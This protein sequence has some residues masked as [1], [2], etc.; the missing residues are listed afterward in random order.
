[1]NTGVGDAVGLG[2]ALGAILNGWGTPQLLN[3]YE[4]ERRSVGL[5]NRE[6]SQHHMSTRV[7]ITQSE[8]RVTSL[9]G[10][11]GDKAR[12]A[13]GKYI[14]ELGN[15]ENEALGIELGYRYYESPIIFPH[16]APSWCV[17]IVVISDPINM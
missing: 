15:L 1:M 14:K 4:T 16:C 3:A 6:A 5:R 10:A 11:A 13:L 17:T 9:D 8:S 12:K 2:W 7:K